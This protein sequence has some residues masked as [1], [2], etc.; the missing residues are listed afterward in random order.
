MNIPE[1]CQIDGNYLGISSVN[2]TDKT[3]KYRKYDEMECTMLGGISTSTSDGYCLPKEDG[4]N[5]N[6]SENCKDAPPKDFFILKTPSSI[7]YL[8]NKCAANTELINDKCTPVDLPFPCPIDTILNIINNQS[9]C[10]YKADMNFPCIE[11][12]RHL[13]K[14]VV[15]GLRVW[16]ESKRPP[17][18]ENSTRDERY[19]V[20]HDNTTCY[21]GTEYNSTTHRCVGVPKCGENT[22]LDPDTNRCRVIV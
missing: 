22:T 13:D 10:V 17:C 14:C 6:F 18:P 9:R 8:S 7:K 1:Y 21:N 12:V 4:N 20:L 2:Q 19:C 15:R 16:P 11:G 3:K 5:I